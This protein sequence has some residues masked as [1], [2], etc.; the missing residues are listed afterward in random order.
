MNNHSVTKVVSYA[1]YCYILRSLLYYYNIILCSTLCHRYRLGHVGYNIILF[2]GY[3]LGCLTVTV[4]ANEIVRFLYEYNILCGR[5]LMAKNNASKN[6]GLGKGG[7]GGHRLTSYN[8]DS[9]FTRFPNNK[10]Y[11][12]FVFTF[13]NI[14]ICSDFIYMNNGYID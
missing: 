4:K 5:V 13:M 8:V 11:K 7:D 3:P 12:N 10:K 2:S 6:V 9:L 1:S 14:G